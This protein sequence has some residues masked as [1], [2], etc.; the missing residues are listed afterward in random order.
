MFQSLNPW[1]YG[2]G[3]YL[4]HRHQFKAKYYDYI[5]FVMVGLVVEGEPN[6]C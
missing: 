3:L 1:I 6:G 4:L 2:I 5:Y